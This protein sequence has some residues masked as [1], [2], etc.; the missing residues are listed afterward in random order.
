[1][2]EDTRVARREQI[3]EAA[4]R[5]LAKHGY[6][7]TSMLKIAKQASASN[8]TL[9]SWYGD[10]KGLFKALV[11]RNASE[12]MAFLGDELAVKRPPRETIDSLGPKLLDLL[13]GAKA[14]ALNRAAAADSSGVLGAAIAEAGRNSV[15]PSIVEIFDSAKEAGQIRTRLSSS[16]VAEIYVNLLVGDLQIRRAI[17]SIDMLTKAIVSQRSKRATALLFDLLTA[18]NPSE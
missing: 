17:G 11:V 18:T 7:G 15:L 12:I 10:K 1:M 5:M 8:E 3:E 13:L 14:V 6:S 2:R 9:Y 16:E 4:Y